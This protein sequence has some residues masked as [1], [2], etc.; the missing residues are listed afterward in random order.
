MGKRTISRRRGRG[1]PTYRSN[2]HR[3]EGEV[4]HSRDGEIGTVVDIIH[5]P[6]RS[7]PVAE[8]EFEDRTEKVLAPEGISTGDKI[9][10]SRD[11]DIEPGNTLPLKQIPEGVPI[12]NIELNPGDGGK[13]ARSAGTYAFVIAH[14]RDSTQ[15]YLPSKNIKQLDPE[16]RAS[17][18]EV[19]GGG[20][21]ERTFRK[22]GDRH[23]LAKA[24]G[25]LYPK[26]SAVAMNATDHPFGGSAEPGKPK[27]VSGS[28][29]PGQKAGSIAASRTG[30]KE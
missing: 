4:K 3:S 18:G 15:V 26:T 14:D 1:T 9:D 28:S 6:S 19:A 20:K 23:H 13:I 30:K 17:I 8:V 10:M 11:A 21:R 5:D 22:A 16:C 24:R 7:A 29:S 12:Y 27:T 2:T 25:E